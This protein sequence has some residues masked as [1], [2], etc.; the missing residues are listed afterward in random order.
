MN[1]FNLITKAK[2]PP[3]GSAGNNNAPANPALIEFHIPAAAQK[4]VAVA[5]KRSTPS[6]KPAQKETPSTVSFGRKRISNQESVETVTEQRQKAN[7]SFLHCQFLIEDPEANY[8]DGPIAKQISLDGEE[9]EELLAFIEVVEKR[10]RK[11]EK[12]QQEKR[13]WAIAKKIYQQESGKEFL[14]DNSISCSANNE[15]GLE[16]WH[17]GITITKHDGIEEVNQPLN[18]YNPQHSWLLES[19]LS[20]QAVS[21]T[22]RRYCPS[23][24]QIIYQVSFGFPDQTFLEA[25][26][27]SREGSILAVAEDLLD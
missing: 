5:D 16:E 1:N 9:F 24:E 26:G 27:P 20:Q 25:E 12:E 21:W 15:T 7:N 11:Q 3:I 22:V 13:S 19:W 14:S 2:T 6:E 10:R 4:A 18:F 23:P 8:I 17:Q